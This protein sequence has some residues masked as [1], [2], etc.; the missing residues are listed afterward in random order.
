MYCTTAWMRRWRQ[1]SQVRTGDRVKGI[2]SRN[3]VLIRGNG[4]VMLHSSELAFD[5]C[6]QVWVHAFSSYN[7]R[8]VAH[9]DWDPRDSVQ[10]LSIIHCYLFLSSDT[11]S[12]NHWFL[13]V[14]TMN[15][16]LFSCAFNNNWLLKLLTA[17]QIP[18]FQEYF[19]EKQVGFNSNQN[20]MVLKSQIK[21]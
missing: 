7:W 11:R 18:G 6:L 3:P 14:S 1:Q 10:W 13:L 9:T 5:R 20:T 17:E 15:N 16:W 21:R 2:L 12:D 4:R 19:F 8:G